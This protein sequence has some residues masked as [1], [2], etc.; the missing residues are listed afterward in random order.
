[1]GTSTERYWR[2]KKLKLNQEKRVEETKEKAK[3]FSEKENKK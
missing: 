1:M 3:E 2:K